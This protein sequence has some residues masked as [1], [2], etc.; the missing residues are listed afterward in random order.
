MLNR[1]QR[2]V[3]ISLFQKSHR[4][5]DVVSMH[6]DPYGCYWHGRHLIPSSVEL[7]VLYE[8]DCRYG[9]THY[10]LRVKLLYGH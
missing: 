2:S 7:S 4:D 8:I 5:T 9:L 1:R 6:Y 3:N 10:R